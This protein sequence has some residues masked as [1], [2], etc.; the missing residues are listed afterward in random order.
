M[1]VR[2]APT[3]LEEPIW[4][5]AGTE[6]VGMLVAELGATVTEQASVRFPVKP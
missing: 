1:T 4:V 6:Q 3:T 5:V 2:F